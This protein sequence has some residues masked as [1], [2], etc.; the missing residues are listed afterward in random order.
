[1]VDENTIETVQDIIQ[2]T[3]ESTGV[4]DVTLVVSDGMSD[5]DSFTTS[6]YI[7]GFSGGGQRQDVDAFLTY[8][9]PLVKSLDLPAGTTTFDVIIFYRSTIEEDTFQASLNR[10]SF[11][12]IF[13]PIAGTSELV[14][15]PLLSP[16]RN[17]LVLEV[18]GVRTDKRTATDRD[19]LVF[20]VE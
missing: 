7:S 16:G 5:S 20:I 2:H 9:S 10:E 11:T 12:H 14:T 17:T 19:G 15:I 6:A 4:F 1:L 18:D 8:G 13:T 3:Y